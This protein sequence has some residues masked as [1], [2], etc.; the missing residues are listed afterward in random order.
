MI[1]NIFKTYGMSI[2]F[3]SSYILADKNYNGGYYKDADKL[4][5]LLHFRSKN[6]NVYYSGLKKYK[7]NPKRILPRLFALPFIFVYSKRLKKD[8]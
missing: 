5:E 3:L 6:L 7:K 4:E 2:R 8:K 1:I